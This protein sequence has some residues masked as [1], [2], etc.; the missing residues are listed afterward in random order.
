MNKFVFIEIGVKGVFVRCE[1]AKNQLIVIN[2]HMSGAKEIRHNPG[3]VMAHVPLPFGDDVIEQRAEKVG[4]EKEWLKEFF[5]L[6]VD[7]AKTIKVVITDIETNHKLGKIEEVDQVRNPD[8]LDPLTLMQRLPE[9]TEVKD[10][11]TNEQ[12]ALRFWSDSW[13][14]K[15]NFRICLSM[16]FAMG[17]SKLL[18]YATYLRGY[19]APLYPDNKE[20]QLVIQKC[21][22]IEKNLKNTLKKMDIEF[23]RVEIGQDLT[24]GKKEG[25]GQ[26]RDPK[27]N[28]LWT[29]E[30]TFTRYP[31]ALTNNKLFINRVDKL[32]NQSLATVE[33]LGLYGKGETTSITTVGLHLPSHFEQLKRKS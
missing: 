8:E 24:G 3:D 2:K 10:S 13:A 5:Q 16:D 19:I 1:T 7:T 6:W 25:A 23:D 32:D 26:V 28:L 27:T 18:I 12:A 29:T 22:Q 33:R 4:I 21:D 14:D 11:W 9:F 20:V 15:K 31:S 17:W 30:S